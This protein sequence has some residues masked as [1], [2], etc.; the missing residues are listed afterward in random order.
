M[1]RNDSET[2]GMGIFSEEA[3]GSGRFYRDGRSG[4]P[5]PPPL[6]TTSETRDIGGIHR[7]EVEREVAAS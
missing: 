2:A 1:R 6:F 4:T 5:I 7:E 3:M